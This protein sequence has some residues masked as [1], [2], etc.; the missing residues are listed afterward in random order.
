MTYAR[1]RSTVRVIK[2]IA[3]DYE[4]KIWNFQPHG[5]IATLSGIGIKET[6][7]VSFDIKLKTLH[8]HLC[9]FTVIIKTCSQID[10]T[11]V[12]SVALATECDN[13]DEN[14][15]KSVEMA[16]EKSDHGFV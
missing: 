5:S 14:D 15:L 6:N 7:T 10:Q 8:G 12:S 11:K 16:L 3:F 13:L 9:M 2:I 4:Y 1:W